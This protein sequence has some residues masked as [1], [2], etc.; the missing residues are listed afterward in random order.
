MDYV[1]ISKEGLFSFKWDGEKR[2]YRKRRAKKASILT[3]L[4]S[5]CRIV[6][7]TTLLDIFRVV[8]K[9]TLL[10]LFIS[11]YSWCRS[12]DEFHAQA[13]EP[14]RS[15]DSDIDYLEIHWTPK[16]EEYDKTVKH[17][18]GTRE[19][20]HVVAF[21]VFVDF[22]GIGKSGTCTHRTD[23][24]ERYGVSYSPMYELAD[25]EVK[26]NHEFSVHKPW[27][28]GD[29]I[30]EN[31]ELLRST[32]SFTLLDVLDAI[33]YDISFMGGPS[34]NVAFLEEMKDTMDK[35]ENGEIDVTEFKTLEDTEEDN[36]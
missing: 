5:E 6:E 17:K 2:A 23:S 35:I 14:M 31:R 25:Y 18:G 27:N 26:L 29:K 22:I 32:R 15:D 9:Y 21:D 11:Q 34:D 16:V 20:H 10:K 4:R 13:E 24:R 7:G 28:A 3:L 33:Y 1:K 30:S 8:D 12:I 36:D 19:R